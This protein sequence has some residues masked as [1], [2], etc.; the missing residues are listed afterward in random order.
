MKTPTII[1]RLIGLYLTS[2]C[3]IA[4]FQIH[5]MSAMPGGMQNPTLNAIETYSVLGLIVGIAASAFAGPIARIL[6]FDAEPG[7]PKDDF[8]DQMLR[9]P[10]VEP[11]HLSEPTR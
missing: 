10:P 1:V 4:L 11:D 9:R 3:S 2:T 6:T 5:E 8:S 7:G